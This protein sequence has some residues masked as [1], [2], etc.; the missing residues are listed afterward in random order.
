MIKTKEKYQTPQLVFFG[1][2]LLTV[3]FISDYLYEK[4]WIFYLFP[5]FLFGLGFLVVFV[6]S[7]IKKNRQGV[8][9]GIIVL[10]VISFSQ[11]TTS[12]FFK[13]K[14]VFEATLMDDLSAIQLNLRENNQ[15]EVTVSTLF[16]EK[17]YKGIYELRENKIIFMDKRYNND[18][19]PDTLTIIGDK[20]ILKFDSE[21]KP[22][23]D[24][25]TYFD[26]RKNTI[27][28]VP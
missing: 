19:I 10:G 5:L 13:S 16:T 20:L 28:N 6:L 3:Y 23:T 26:I 17:V 18:F 14:K 8:L 24:F 4:L 27:K 7:I 22:K 25:A 15:F 2:L 9:I 1:I 12:E 11:L 21:G